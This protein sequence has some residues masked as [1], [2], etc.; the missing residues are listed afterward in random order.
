MTPAARKGQKPPGVAV[1]KF[2][3]LPIKLGGN[4][5]FRL[6][7]LSGGCVSLELE[8]VDLGFRIG[9]RSIGIGPCEAD[10]ERGKQ[11]AVDDDRR[12]IRPRDPG[13]PQAF[14][15]LERLNSKAVI[16]ALHF[17][18]PGG[19]WIEGIMDWQKPM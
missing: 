13:M 9:D 16:F 7:H 19:S 10:F 5:Q 15:S 11:N 3:A 18:T 1:Q 12:Q 8:A 4:P 17:P 6:R 14:S 2:L